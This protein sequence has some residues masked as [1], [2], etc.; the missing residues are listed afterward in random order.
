MKGF[1]FNSYHI[2][3]CILAVITA[4]I[5]ACSF[6]NSYESNRYHYSAIVLG[7]IVFFGEITLIILYHN[8]LHCSNKVLNLL[9][10]ISIGILLG[11]QIWIVLDL[12]PIVVSDLANVYAEAVNML[13]KNGEITNK[14][15]FTS[16]SH[17]LPFL[18]VLYQLFRLG[19]IFGIKDFAVLGGLFN[20]LLITISVFLGYL[21]MCKLKGKS[22]ATFF[23]LTCVLNPALYFY[24]PYFYSDTFC[25][26]FVML[27]IYFIVLIKEK[28]E[29]KSIQYFLYFL[30]GLTVGFGFKL[31][32]TVFI[33]GFAVILYLYLKEKLTDFLKYTIIIVFGMMVAVSSYKLY[34]KQYVHFDTEAKMFPW[35]H[36]VM[37]GVKG[38]GRWNEED[39][40]YTQSLGT[41]EEKIAGNIKEIKNRVVHLGPIGVFRLVINKIRLTWSSGTHAYQIYIKGW[42]YN[43]L[44]YRY[45]VEHNKVFS[46]WC[47]SFQ[48]FMMGLLLLGLFA[49]IR[50][51]QIDI[52]SIMFLSIFGAIFFYIFWEVRPRYSIF[53][54][55]LMHIL[56]ILG[57][58]VVY[59]INGLE[60]INCR[61]PIVKNKKVFRVSKTVRKKIMI[62]AGAF[63][64]TCSLIIVGIN[65]TKYANTKKMEYHYCVKQKM[66][67]GP[68]I[69]SLEKG[70]TFIQ[71]FTTDQ[72]FR[73]LE[74]KFLNRKKYEDAQYKINL[75]KSN[76]DLLTQKI[77]SAA[78]LDKSGYT[79]MKFKKVKPKRE[80]TYKISIGS[81]NA[82]KNNSL[83]LGGCSFG[84]GYHI[85]K[86]G[87][88]LFNG[89]QLNGDLAFKVYDKLPQPY[90]TKWGY[91][92]LSLILIGA[93]GII[94]ILYI[95]KG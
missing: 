11:I 85:V 36:Y 53:V 52:F 76:G 31:R 23:L 92:V 91:I 64:I 27:I 88:T 84:E 61:L 82:T 90:F 79:K 15:Y 65:F 68:L 38:E 59:K 39:W 26:P 46:Y 4:Y 43:S 48:C 20:G 54:I 56:M 13:K 71:T 42:N 18:L 67:K 49:Q 66:V 33:I 83:G 45:M 77:I 94:L 10:V 35:T 24:V 69:R 19:S 14:G 95:R 3:M 32:A 41:K 86:G 9:A 5:T 30:L 47:Q 25:I 40:A 93:E 60:D 16:Y 2:V 28:E 72:D 29:K 50:K 7:M 74:I 87:Q 58:E 6:F 89:K 34:Q 55:L 75:M 44:V 22:V 62:K 70:D 21:I 73:Y 63:G 80:E 17:Q 1:K 12:K 57:Q 37:M 81:Y 8:L 78:D 51:K